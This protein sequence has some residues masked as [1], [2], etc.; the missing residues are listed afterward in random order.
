M[1]FAPNDARHGEV[2]ECR[3]SNAHDRNH[4][5]L[6]RRCVRRAALGRLRACSE[7]DQCA[8][9]R[10]RFFGLSARDLARRQARREPRWPARGP[11][12]SARVAIDSAEPRAN[13]LRSVPGARKPWPWRR[14]GRNRVRVTGDRRREG[15]GAAP[16]RA[17][18]GQNDVRNIAR[19]P[20]GVGASASCGPRSRSWA[21]TADEARA[22]AASFTPT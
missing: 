15:S 2:H 18:R 4:G 10:S 5:G 9:L 17:R 19:P 6:A 1:S 16:V 8:L 14:F 21:R 3:A 22:V 20:S 7:R 11:A 13:R 12:R